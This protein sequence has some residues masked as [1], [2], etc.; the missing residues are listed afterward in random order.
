MATQYATFNGTATTDVQSAYVRCTFVVYVIND[1]SVN[2]LYVG[3]SA[4]GVDDYI[5]I[6]PKEKM[7][8]FPINIS[9][10]HLYY[11][12]LASTAN[13]RFFGSKE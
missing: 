10:G 9:C 5:K 6:A 4:N 12:T 3:F 8:G 11:K 13:F 1:D 7:S 2:D